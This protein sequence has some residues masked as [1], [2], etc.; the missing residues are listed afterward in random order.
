MLLFVRI[1]WKKIFRKILTK[2]F[3]VFTVIL[4]V[5]IKLILNLFHR[6]IYLFITFI[7]WNQFF[8]WLLK[9]TTAKHKTESHNKFQSTQWP[10]KSEICKNKLFVI[11]HFVPITLI[12]YLYFILRQNLKKHELTVLA[13]FYYESRRIHPLCSCWFATLYDID[14]IKGEKFNCKKNKGKKTQH[15]QHRSENKSAVKR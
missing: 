6:F 8:D 7:T 4:G 1:S 15:F 13:L 11:F 12:A 3:S 2:P 5:W 9:S 10:S 14:F